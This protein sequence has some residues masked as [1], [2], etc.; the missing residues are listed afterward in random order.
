MRERIGP[1]KGYVRLLG[2]YCLNN[3]KGKVVKVSLFSK[4]LLLYE[5]ASAPYGCWQRDDWFGTVLAKAPVY[6]V[7]TGE[8]GWKR[9]L[10]EVR[11]QWRGAETS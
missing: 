4:R 11:V 7:L 10:V 5:L 8:K 2:V 1:K 3:N 9:A 6:V